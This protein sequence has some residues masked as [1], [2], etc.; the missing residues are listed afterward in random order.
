MPNESLSIP[1][2]IKKNFGIELSQHKALKDQIYPFARHK[3]FLSKVETAKGN[4]NNNIL[5]RPESATKFSNAVILQGFL[6]DA[7]KVR[8][9]FDDDGKRQ[10]FV[11]FVEILL[12]KRES[13]L[14]IALQNQNV[15]R[16][17]DILKSAECL[18][19]TALPNPFTALPQ[20]LLKA[21]SNL[22]QAMLAQSA[23][24]FG[25]SMMLHYLD[26]DLENA[27]Q[28]ACLLKA[29]N[30]VLDKF[31]RL[32]KRQYKEAKEF[33]SLLKNLFD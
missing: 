23:L 13:V 28:A 15:P 19:E 30:P 6:G 17:I 3:T 33:D 9:I 20:L 29:E 5:I 22:I 26:D 10:E 21:N 4:H 24:S 18:T 25:E 31:Q 14:G 1:Q 7:T 8:K 11:E 12:E 27:Y 32:V 2:I 16:F